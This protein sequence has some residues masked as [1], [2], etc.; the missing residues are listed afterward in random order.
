VRMDADFVAAVEAAFATGRE[1]RMAA[2][3]IYQVDRRAA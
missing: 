2:S 3:V 1:S